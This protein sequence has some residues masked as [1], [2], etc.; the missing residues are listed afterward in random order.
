MSNVNIG[1][2]VD[3]ISPKKTNIYTPV[4]ELIVNSLQAIEDLER[5]DGVVSVRV[6][7]SQQTEMYDDDASIPEIVGFEVQDNGVGFTDEHLDSFDTLYTEK[8]SAEGGKGFG[9]FT[10]LKYFDRFDVE[11]VYRN[12]NEFKK[13]KFQM[14]RERE[15]IV[16]KESLEN[17]NEQTGT[18][19]RLTKPKKVTKFEKTLDPL[20][21]NITERIL[22][23]LI[24]P[25]YECPK[26]I[27]SEHD[28][29]NEK[30]LN[31]ISNSIKQI[32]LE[33]N[34]FEL[35][36]IHQNIQ[37]FQVQMY[38]IYS[39]GNQK[40]RIS[41]IAHKREVTSCWLSKYVPE[42]EEA[43]FD[44]G[45]ENE[46]GH[47]YIIKAHV[48][49][50][51]LD[52]NVLVERGGFEFQEKT[53][54][55][56]GIS[57]EDIEREVVKLS[58]AVFGNE[59]ESRKENKRTRVQDYVDKNSPWL[60]R[61]LKDIDLSSLPYI[62]S[63]EQIE[64]FIHKQ[65]F[66]EE[67]KVRSD[68]KSILKDTDPN[69]LQEKARDI[70]S[71]V[72]E[73]SR[74]ELTHYVALRK[75]ALDLLEK[76]LEIDDSGNYFSEKVVHNIIFPQKGDS[77]S[78]SFEDH[79]L[80]ILD[81]RLNFTEYV[82]SDKRAYKNNDNRPDIL[83][84]GKRILFR[85]SNVAS[86]P[87]TIF[88]FKKPQRDNFANPSSIE[89]PVE[90]LIRYVND[91]KEGKCQTPKGRDINIENNTPAYGYIVC[92]AT[93]KFRD[94]IEKEQDFK[95]TPDGQGWFIYRER[96]NLYIEVITWDKLLKD[97]IMRN[98]IFFEKLG[99]A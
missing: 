67:S 70:V 1:R 12:G 94:W 11:S 64:E 71:R 22:P 4:V 96:I 8:R 76:S 93:P 60:K 3:N 19:I 82:S 32:Q 79:N 6:L 34:T 92:D 85:E 57:E 30:I 42:F 81:E 39:P 62:S 27:L 14:G 16:G 24:T 45:H 97:A 18:T 33:Q 84:Y 52:K 43:F 28:G 83:A 10:C 37:K 29:S 75:S 80:W 41:L 38:K 72:L 25:G 61:I 63:H 31:D 69:N 87:I 35:Q 54:L 7:R 51:Y 99:I 21:K 23:Y 58:M 91:I 49:G 36:D 44:E 46:Y 40:N 88:E 47:K 89:N 56:L 90:Q 86:N 2:L 50:E 5:N 26:L 53:D 65:K 17:E 95:P 77:D 20:S 9:R 55:V 59:I 73:S 98:K 68:V 66:K 78:T 15:I 74:D 13:R 48:F